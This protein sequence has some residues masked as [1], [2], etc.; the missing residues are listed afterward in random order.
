ME[1]TPAINLIEIMNIYHLS[2]E[3]EGERKEK[4]NFVITLQ[5]SLN[6]LPWHSSSWIFLKC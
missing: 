5:I 1:W 6:S 3:L 4:K 2:G